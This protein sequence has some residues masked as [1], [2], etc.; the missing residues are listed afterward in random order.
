MPPAATLLGGLGLEPFD[1]ASPASICTAHCAAR[2]VAIKQ[3]LL[4]G[5][6]VVGAGNIYACEALFRAGIDPRTWPRAAVSRPRCERLAEAVRHILAQALD[7]GGSTLRDYR[8][9]HGMAGSFQQHAAVYG[10]E[11]QPCLACGTDPC[12]ASCKAS[13]RAS[14]ARTASGVEATPRGVTRRIRFP[15]ARCVLPCDND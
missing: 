12:G 1:P 7:L 15:P 9:A 11:G 5:D 14:S 2:R 4:A 3:A 10:R 13:A 6:I 8:D